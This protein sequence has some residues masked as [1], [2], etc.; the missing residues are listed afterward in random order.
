MLHKVFRVR[1]LVLVSCFSPTLQLDFGTLIRAK[2]VSFCL[3]GCKVWAFIE[4]PSA[5]ISPSCHCTVT[6]SRSSRYGIPPFKLEAL[7]S[8]V[9][10]F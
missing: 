7:T 1:T 8:P 10:E 3:R 4:I 2:D 5:S 9:K 6:S